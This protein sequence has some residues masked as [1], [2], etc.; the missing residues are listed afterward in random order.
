MY[1]LL[2]RTFLHY[3]KP[4]YNTMYLLFRYRLKYFKSIVLPSYIIQITFNYQI[5]MF[6]LLYIAR[7]RLI[8]ITN[9]YNIL[10]T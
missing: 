3:K 10:Y 2:F 1:T 4:V 5:E 7:T 8:R 9:L 6:K